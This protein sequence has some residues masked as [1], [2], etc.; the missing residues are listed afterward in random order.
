MSSLPVQ[1]IFKALN[2]VGLHI[3][4]EPGG[5]LGVAPASLL[6]SELRDL[7]RGNKAV[8]VDYLR[9][10]NDP[11]N[12]PAKAPAPEPPTDPNAWRELAAAYHQHH[13]TCPTCIAAGK[14]YGLRCGTGAAL[15]AA[16]STEQPV[17][18][19]TPKSKRTD[20]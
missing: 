5:A 4:L 18:P 16:Y 11:T 6:T 9:A 8:L 7:I 1:H 10:A 13:F 12:D 2:D 15:W 19:T 14:G 20:A 17:A 3:S